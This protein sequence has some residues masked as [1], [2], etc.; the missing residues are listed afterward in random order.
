MIKIKDKTKCCG[1]TACASICPKHCI[2]MKED[3]EGF[4]YP[5]ADASLCVECG[6]CEKV[7]P[8]MHAGAARKP[9]HCYAAKNRDAEVLK[10]SSSGGIFSLLAQYAICKKQGVVFGAMW[11]GD[12]VVH[13]AIESL[14]ELHKFRG[15]KYVQSDMRDSFKQVA[16]F[17]KDGRFVLFSGTPCEIAGL[18]SYIKKDY[19]NL[20]TVDLACHGVPS[21]KVLELYIQELKQ[22]YGVESL[23]LNFKD[24]STGWATYS[25]A[26]KSGVRTLFSERATEN[27][28]MKGYVHELFSRPS[29]H[30]CALKSFRSGSDITLADFWGIEKVLPECKSEE[31]VSLVLESTPK[32]EDIIK[33]VMQG[34]EKYNVSYEDAIRDNGALV[35]SQP[36]HPQRRGFFKKFNKTKK[37]T[38]EIINA[39]NLRL[40]TKTKLFTRGIIQRLKGLVVS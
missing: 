11:E 26:A 34:H 10:K 8:V 27:I 25:V 2:S 15:S 24:K 20:L 29:C 38:H 7:C 19:D 35:H 13:G 30:C 16:A 18:N 1:C 23:Q 36:P 22:K 40:F 32:G 6:A 17:L 31:G 39:L 21:P 12:R 5:E 4:L 14:E 9:L 28:Y 37:I 3:K 33:N